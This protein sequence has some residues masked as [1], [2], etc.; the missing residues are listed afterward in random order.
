MANLKQLAAELAH[1]LE[2]GASGA[3]GMSVGA[4]P[5]GGAPTAN[6]MG[7]SF[8]GIGASAGIPSCASCGAPQTQSGPCP[9]CFPHGPPMKPLGGIGGVRGFAVWR[10]TPKRK[11]K[12]GKKSKA[13]K[14]S[15]R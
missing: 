7:G 5:A 15:K 2:D 3:A 11:K 8:P 10:K 13:K 12:H 1:L 4:A 6:Y 9:G 14:A